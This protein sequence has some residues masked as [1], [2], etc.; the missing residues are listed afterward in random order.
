MAELNVC[1]Y[2]GGRTGHLYA[3]LFK[4]AE[5]VRV[6]LLSRKAALIR[7]AMTADG[8]HVLLPDG[9]S[10]RG[11]PDVVTDKPG[12]VIP[13]ADVVVVALPAHVRPAALRA[14][15]SQLATHKPVYVG[16]V[17]GNGGFDWLAAGLLPGN[18]V[19][20]G[21]RDTPSTAYDLMPGSSVS[22][23]CTIEEVLL[24]FHDH[25]QSA[26]RRKAQAL[27]EYLF[28]RRITPVES[29]LEITL[30]IGN[31]VLHIPALYGLA[32]PYSRNPDG[33]F[34]KR[35]SW[36]QDVTELG[37]YF[38]ERCAAEQY[39]LIRRLRHRSGLALASLRPLHQELVESFGQHIPDKSSIYTILRTN[40]AFK[41]MVPLRRDEGSNHLT[42]DPASRVF[43]EDT[44][45]GLILL[46][47]VAQKLGVQPFHLAEISSWSQRFADP[48][49]GLATDYLP[50]TWLSAKQPTYAAPHE[51]WW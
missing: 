23:G 46:M 31:P 6:S 34:E 26:E 27:L 49:Y 18:A 43:H 29:F 33:K 50:E 35:L 19:I 48:A 5:D 47:Q 17:P 11:R 32:G 38:V 7:Q 44:S 8:I 24:A 51:T 15:A 30:A 13:Q 16:A 25:T 2:G 21:F 4:Q 1:I 12:A 20:W 40:K 41:G 9:G 45:F 28:A 14:I 22:L 10:L 36:W 42:L 37:A 39:D 3:A